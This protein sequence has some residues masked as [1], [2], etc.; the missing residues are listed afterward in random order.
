MVKP[1]LKEQLKVKKYLRYVD[2]FA[3]FSNDKDSLRLLRAQIEEHLITL[4]LKIHPI[5]SQ[6][7]Q[8]IHSINFLGFRIL[9]KQ[10]RVSCRNLHP[11]RRRL[12]HL[13][14][15]YLSGKLTL[16][17]VSQSVQGWL[18][19]LQQGDIAVAWSVRT[20]F[21]FQLAAF[22]LSRLGRGAGG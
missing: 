1:V 19:H 3:L 12:K 11:G 17:D 22:P 2:D 7:F 6:I 8:S 20:S 13:Q 10:V 14:Q 9:L 21:G 16:E 5:K 15:H 4:R 18:G